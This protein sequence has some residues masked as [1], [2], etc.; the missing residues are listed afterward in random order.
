MTCAIAAALMSHL[1]TNTDLGAQAVQFMHKFGRIFQHRG[2]GGNFRRWIHSDNPQPYG[3]FGNGA[4]MRVSACGL[5]ANTLD[6]AKNYARKVTEVT[7]NHP[8]GIKGGESV[9]AAIFLAKSG[10]D[11]KEIKQYINDNYYK[12]DFTISQ[13]RESYH[14]DVTCMGCV[15]QAIESFLESINFENSIRIAISLGGDS[16]TI[17][18]ITGSIAEAY[19]KGIPQQFVKVIFTQYLEEPLTSVVKDFYMLMGKPISF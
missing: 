14:F 8:E 17:A 9:A 18:A 10:K 12:L 4:A 15:P 5:F 11:K 7:H 13:I 3:S 6:E 1:R 19:Y 2:Y 16:D